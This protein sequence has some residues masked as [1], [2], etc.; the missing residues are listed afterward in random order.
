MGLLVASIHRLE[1]I[2]VNDVVSETSIVTR[3]KSLRES[4]PSDDFSFSHVQKCRLKCSP[5]SC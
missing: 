4:F 3:K 1:M 5:K 2:P